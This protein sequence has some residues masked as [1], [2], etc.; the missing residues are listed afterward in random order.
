[1][2]DAQKFHSDP[3]RCQSTAPTPSRSKSTGVQRVET[4]GGSSEEDNGSLRQRRRAT[5]CGVPSEKQESDSEHPPALP[6]L[7]RAASGGAAKA[8]SSR[9]FAVAHAASRF[10][11]NSFSGFSAVQQTVLASIS[12]TELSPK[13]DS[14]PNLADADLHLEH[15][16]LCQE[17][18]DRLKGG[19]PLDNDE[20]LEQEFEALLFYKNRYVQARLLHFAMYLSAGAESVEDADIVRVVLEARANP[21]GTARYT[22]GEETNV[23]QPIHIAAGLGNVGAMKLLLEKSE[24]KDILL[25]AYCMLEGKPFYVPLHD[26]AYLG[27]TNAVVWL[28]ETGA[29]ASKQNRDGYTP[30]HWL[31]QVGLESENDLQIMVRSLI[32]HKA[33]LDMR[34]NP[35]KG[36]VEG[37]LPLE[38]AAADASL[39]P[40][41]LLH[42]L[43]PSF[44]GATREGNA[45]ESLSFFEDLCLLSSLNTDAAKHLARRLMESEDLDCRN[46]LL[47]DA[48]M[49]NSVDRMANLFHMAPEVAAD[50]MELLSVKPVVQD[51]GR[52]PIR[53]RASLWGLFY[54]T[55]MRCAYQPDATKKNGLQW[56]EWRFDSRKEDENLR[57]DQPALIWHL[58]LVKRPSESEERR[59]YVQDVT[60][61]ALLIP[62]MIDIDIFMALASTGTNGARIFSK[63]AV[64]GIIYFLWDHLICYAIYVRIFFNFI[65]LLVQVLWGLQGSAQGMKAP[66]QAPL[67]WSI[68]T[69]GLLTDCVN[70]CWWFCAHYRKWKG[71]YDDFC[72]WQKKATAQ[73]P[74]GLHALWRLKSFFTT[75]ML[76]SDLPLCVIK[77]AFVWDVGCQTQGPMDDRPQT[78][79]A[80]C[81]LMQ[82][83]KLFYILR[84]T[85][86]GRKVTTIFSA[87]FSGAISEMLLVTWLFF[88]CVCLAF[89][90]LKRNVAGMTSG[91]QIYRGLLFGDGDAL[92]YMGLGRDDGGIHTGLMLI[93]TLLFNIVIGNL[94]TA[95]Y[96]SEY[97]RL[98][99]EAE[100]HFQRERAKCCCE[101]L[102]SLQKL[103]LPADGSRD[104]VLKVLRALV[105]VAFP[106]GF[107]LH[108]L[109][110]VL[111][112]THIWSACLLSFGQLTT[113]ALLLN[114]PWFPQREDGAE[115]PAEPHFL[116]ICTRSDFSEEDFRL[117]QLDKDAL[118]SIVDERVESL[119][120]KVQE[121]ISRLD[122]R[123]EHLSGNLEEKIVGLSQQMEKL[124]NMQEQVLAAR[125]PS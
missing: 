94:T 87:F 73:R 21:Q 86:C 120:L 81:S 77:A 104:H 8:V 66:S 48:Q 27:K 75:S 2:A 32:K 56:P 114:S 119:E 71:H 109:D 116:W 98:E 92:D 106:L 88:C 23:L 105:V 34:T 74:P 22:K 100:L 28:L 110:T 5:V 93:A 57:R 37:Q 47:A 29:E 83:C 78:L 62:N 3:L 31:A 60:T 58:D 20:E 7:V 111:P 25:N 14:T 122:R 36:H 1:M 70:H 80:A 90:M 17:R 16:Q 96:G 123:V 124:L 9:V 82:F 11:R 89:S 121:Q 43:A 115:G 45:Q 101:L 112:I 39:F 72:D 67:F 84:V 6:E 79:L 59:E 42:L 113:M 4:A 51:P 125:L 69:A 91:L 40:R 15:K 65:E 64:Q 33:R 44:Q 50:I 85:Q 108:L 38:L 76:I 55:T 18:L 35:S 26:A 68:T 118:S 46:R 52:H 117:E 103:K 24:D 63:L 99:A 12:Q 102:L 53:T 19:E 13:K 107:G 54:W 97:E 41:H 95:V 10:R 61:R 30:L 49:T